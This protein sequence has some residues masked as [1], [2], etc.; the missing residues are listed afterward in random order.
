M[1]PEIV[2]DVSKMV[3]TSDDELNCEKEN[4]IKQN[5]TVSLESL[6]PNVIKEPAKLCN[7]RIGLFYFQFAKIFGNLLKYR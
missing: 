1:P 5:E 3:Q 4:N 6:L 7:F 2:H